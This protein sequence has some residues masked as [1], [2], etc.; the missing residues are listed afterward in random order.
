[1]VIEI[2]EL[3]AEQRFNS[4]LAIILVADVAKQPVANLTRKTLTKL[5]LHQK[6]AN[7]HFAK[8][9]CFYGIFSES[10]KTPMH[11][12]MILEIVFETFVN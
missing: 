11:H 2:Y 5:Y 6:H 7:L 12:I 10:Y 8:M 3:G 9:I 1:M 4:N